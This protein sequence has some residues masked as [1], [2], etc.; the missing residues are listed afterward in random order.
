MRELSR[1]QNLVFRSGALLMI[2]GAAT[3]LFGGMVS[4]LLY[5]IG[6]LMY[7]TMQ[8]R[9]TYYGNNVTLLRLRRQQLLGATALVFSAAALTAQTLGYNLIQHNEWVICLLIG[10]ML[11]LYTSFRIPQELEKEKK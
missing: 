7:A 9:T 5:V 2:V 4:C 8:L 1:I 3:Y 6:T 10:A 11:E